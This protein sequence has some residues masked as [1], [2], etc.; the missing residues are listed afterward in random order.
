MKVRAQA[1]KAAFMSHVRPEIKERIKD[2][3]PVSLEEFRSTR[4]NSYEQ[5]LMQ[6]R[7]D[8]AALVAL[9]RQY[10]A[11]TEFGDGLAEWELPKH[12][13]DAIQRFFLPMLIDRV[14][15]LEY[16]RKTLKDEN[17]KLGEDN[18]LLRAGPSISQKSASD[19]S[20]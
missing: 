3:A 20:L 9:A 14:E 5:H 16:E 13:D 10:L 7:L 2:P 12:Y 15:S 6:E 4:K 8:D 19:P 11:Q 1:R 17:E 18:A